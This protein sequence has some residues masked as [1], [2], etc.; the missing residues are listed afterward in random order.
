MIHHTQPYLVDL[1]LEVVKAS[2]VVG[3]RAQKYFVGVI[4]TKYGSCACV[5]RVQDF[6]TG[7]K[8]ALSTRKARGLLQ[9]NFFSDPL[10]FSLLFGRQE[11]IGRLSGR[12]T[13]A[14]CHMWGTKL[15]KLSKA[16]GGDFFI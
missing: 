5:A 12:G 15:T 16:L 13:K 2:L 8:L 9:P 14:R 7:V 6:R 11:N 3:R 10:H 4:L 1:L